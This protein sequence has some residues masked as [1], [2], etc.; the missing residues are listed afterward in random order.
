V[1]LVTPAPLYLEIFRDQPASAI[2]GITIQLAHACFVAVSC[3]IVQAA[4]QLLSAQ[5]VNP[6]LL[7]LVEY[8]CVQQA[9]I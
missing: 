2:S 6:H 1:L 4:V 8:V 9:L 7:L 5:F 3:Q